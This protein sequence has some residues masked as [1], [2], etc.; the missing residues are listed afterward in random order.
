M[1]L[2]ERGRMLPYIA[3]ENTHFRIATGFQHFHLFFAPDLLTTTFAWP[4]SPAMEDGKGMM[5]KS[6]LY[7][8][9]KD[10][11]LVVVIAMRR[12][13]IMMMS[14][15]SPMENGREIP[16]LEVTSGSL[17]SSRVTSKN[18]RRIM[19]SVIL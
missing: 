17:R 14:P 8:R 12:R 11:D 18:Q 7:I 13:M 9:E 2:P 4:P 6:A 1:T 10:D 16:P 3:P 19:P 15:Q 5:M